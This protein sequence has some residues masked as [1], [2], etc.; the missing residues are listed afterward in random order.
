MKGQLISG[1]PDRVFSG[2][3]LDSRVVSGG[4]LFFALE[5]EQ[6]D[7][8]RFVADAASR[9]AVG[10]VVERLSEA[11]LP[12]DFGLIRVPSTL[13]ALYALT[14]H[15][16]Q[17]VPRQLVGVTGSAGKTT[18]KTLLAAMLAEE[19][20]TASSQGNLNNLFG[21]PLSLL[22][23]PDDS[24]WM[25]AEMGMSEPGELAGVS[26]L[27]RP[28]VVVLTNVAPAHLAA[29]GEVRAIAEAKA[30]IFE[31]LAEQGTVVANADDPEIV[32]ITLR[33]RSRSGCR[34]AWWS[35][36]GQ[37]PGEE[38]PQLLVRSLECPVAGEPGSRFE[39]WAGA[40]SAEL[41]LDLLGLHNVENCLAAATAAHL[42]GVSLEAIARAV[43]QVQAA[44]MRG[45]MVD[46]GV[47]ARVYDDSY[48]SNPEAVARALTAAADIPAGRHWA[49]LGEMLELGEGAE[50]FHLEVGRRAASLGFDPVVGV[51]ELA[52][53][54]VVGAGEKGVRTHW[55]ATAAEA[56]DAAE[57]EVRAEDL[58]LVKG[59]RGVGLEVVV[60]RLRK[61]G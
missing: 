5:G 52:R 4:E 51:G 12:D 45:V 60:E 33:H 26:R 47:G 61:D 17:A 56:A 36:K 53:A 41:R 28:D 8:H 59:S 48:N 57:D 55:F 49:I 58:L 2:A 40:E 42:C 10:A 11:A 19:F 50:T 38:Q 39:L 44:P 1:S 3:A 27:G 34:V 30:E 25:V 9:G 35:A 22:S 23:I 32:R 29:F 18:T 43:E 24:Q 6:S 21:F 46:L 54:L 14:R 15:V 16:R 31:G 20:S 13:E 7:G 37:A